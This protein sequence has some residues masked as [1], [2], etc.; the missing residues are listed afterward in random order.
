MANDDGSERLAPAGPHNFSVTVT[1]QNLSFFVKSSG[2]DPDDRI[3]KWREREVALLQGV[4]GWFEPGNMSALMGPSGSGKTTLLDLLAER[5]TS[6]RSE[7]ELR[8]SGIRPSREYLRRYCGYVEQFDTLLPI[9]TVREMLLY[10]AELKRP[11]SEPLVAKTRAAFLLTEA[12]V[13]A[14]PVAAVLVRPDEPTTGLDSY[15]AHEVMLTVQAVA[16]GGITV[17]ATLHSPTAFCFSLFDRLMMLV[18]GRTVY[19]GPQDRRAVEYFQSC[20]PFLESDPERLGGPGPNSAEFLVD[21]ITEG[22]RDGKGPAFA[23][24]YES[25]PLAAENAAELAA[26][27]ATFQ[28]AHVPPDLAKELAVKGATVTPWWWAIRTYMKY[29]TRR[30]YCDPAFLLPRIC[31]KAVIA[32]LVMTLYWGTGDDLAPHNVLNLAAVLFMWSATQGFVAAS[33]V[34][35]LVLERGL[36]VRERNDGLYLPTTYLTAK[37]LDEIIVNAVASLG[38][39]AFTFYGIQLQNSFAV[40]YVSYTVG[41]CVGI[42]MAYCV[43]S[44]AP[45]M[46]VANVLLPTYAGTLLFFS[47]FLIRTTVMPPWWIWYSYIVFT[48]YSWGAVMIN[49]FR[50]HDVPWIGGETVLQYYELE[51]ASEWTY[52]GYTSL[53]FLFFYSVTALVLTFKR[54]QVR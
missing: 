15:T 46:D 8:Y 43:A 17:V 33:Y 12:P 49:Q 29:R 42:S 14:G 7:G 20:R 5:K 4:S 21:I 38:I 35:S 26:H 54:Y 52:V 44:F 51:G 23:D 48:R 25:S 32:L 45:N 2:K 18:G 22:D 39:S 3:R 1:F 34:P 6:G 31:D 50:N 10:T 36:F 47:G 41:V 28:S 19:F 9:L 16:R 24:A 40:F 13:H 27:L 53:F 30:H 11:V 37:M